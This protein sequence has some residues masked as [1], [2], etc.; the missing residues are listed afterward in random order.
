[1][2]DFT[3][4]IA[5]LVT[6]V[7]LVRLRDRVKGT[8]KLDFG[9]WLGPMEKAERDVRTLA[10]SLV[11]RRRKSRGRRKAP[12]SESIRYRLVF[13]ERD[14]SLWRG[15]FEDEATIIAKFLSLL[16]DLRLN[17]SPELEELKSLNRRNDYALHR[18]EAFTKRLRAIADGDM[19]GTFEDDFPIYRELLSIADSL[20]EL[21]ARVDE[22]ADD[23]VRL[24]GL[25]S[26]GVDSQSLM[27]LM[28][29]EP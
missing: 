11:N 19:T 5:P 28:T 26:S 13:F 14:F 9:G 6:A 2:S 22:K 29:G 20:Q 24:V 12:E 4:D 10:D 15:I 8:T 18:V 3:D 21:K 1:L 25:M 7:R 16:A 27:D 17:V 23:A